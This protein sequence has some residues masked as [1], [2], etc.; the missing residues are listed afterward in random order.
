MIQSIIMI[1]EH[2]TETHRRVCHYKIRFKNILVMCFL[3]HKVKKND[4]FMHVKYDIK[5]ILK[6]FAR[7]FLIILLKKERILMKL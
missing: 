2:Q 6:K 1:E 5:K 3:N 4:D 7:H